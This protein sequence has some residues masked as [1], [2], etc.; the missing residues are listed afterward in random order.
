[1]DV[2]IEKL[3]ESGTSPFRILSQKLFPLSLVSDQKL[4]SIHYNVGDIKKAV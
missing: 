2:W 3:L 4:Q 1:M